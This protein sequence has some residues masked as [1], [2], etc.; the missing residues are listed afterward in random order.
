VGLLTLKLTDHTDAVDSILLAVLAAQIITLGAPAEM[1]VGE[2]ASL[3]L[4]RGER[5]TVAG[6]MGAS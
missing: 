4:T 3:V 5:P 1:M 2:P 6:A